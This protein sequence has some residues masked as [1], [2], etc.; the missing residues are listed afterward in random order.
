VNLFRTA[1]TNVQA[2]GTNKKRKTVMTRSFIIVAGLATLAVVAV[3][4]LASA[5][6]ASLQSAHV[7]VAMNSPA[8]A[9]QT[10]AASDAASGVTTRDR[11][12]GYWNRIANARE[13]DVVRPPRRCATY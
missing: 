7:R 10:D 11:W 6:M 8:G 4:S 9:S 1:P 13:L 5:R 3:G 2:P 12:A